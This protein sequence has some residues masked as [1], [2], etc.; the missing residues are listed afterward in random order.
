MGEMK[1]SHYQVSGQILGPDAKNDPVHSI[2]P[3][4][5]HS[6]TA[7]CSNLELFCKDVINP[8]Q[9]L[10]FCSWAKLLLKL[11]RIKR[12][13]MNVTTLSAGSDLMF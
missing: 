8:I 6:L 2:H 13:N 1:S 11:S 5:P 4:H 7:P 12:T 3:A 10:T 9:T